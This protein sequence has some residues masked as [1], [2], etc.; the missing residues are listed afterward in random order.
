MVFHFVKTNA[1]TKVHRWFLFQLMVKTLNFLL[2][3]YVTVIEVIHVRVSINNNR[4]RRHFSHFA[5]I[6]SI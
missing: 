5:Y 6:F 4:E 1:E 3:L 2:P